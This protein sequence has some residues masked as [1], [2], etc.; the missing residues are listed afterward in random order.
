LSLIN[1]K[2]A[3][4]GGLSAI[5]VPMD[6]KDQFYKKLKKK[7]EEETTFPSDYLFK[8]IVPTS[9]Q[10]ISKVEKLF[11]HMGAVIRKKTSK[12][13]TFTSISIH[14]QVESADAVILKYREAEKI[15]GIISL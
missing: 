3:R 6:S 1:N 10:T 7:L 5:T 9:V 13:G 8:F 11:D 12:K 2:P 4:P 14:L 15:E